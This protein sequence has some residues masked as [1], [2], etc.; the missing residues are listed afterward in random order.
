MERRT[1]ARPNIIWFF[2]DQHRGQATGYAGDP[3]LSTPTM[4]RMAREGI[5]VPGAI[6]NNPWCSPFRF[7]LMTGLYPHHGVYRN[8]IRMDPALPTVATM[9]G[10]AGYRTHYYGK[11]HLDAMSDAT[12]RTYVVP[13]ERAIPRERRG[14]FDTWLGH[15]LRNSHWDV[16]LHGHDEGGEVAARRLP[17]YETDCLTELVLERIGTEHRRQRPTDAAPFFITC[18][19]QPPHWP[20][21]APRE[22]MTRHTP[23]RVRLRPNVPLVPRIREASRRQHAGYY[24]QIENIDRNLQR[25]MDKLYELGISDETLLF[26]FSDHGDCMGSH[27]YFEKSSPWEESIRIPFLIHG[28]VPYAGLRSDALDVPLSAVDI[29]PTTLGLAGAEKPPELPGFDWSPYHR[30]DCEG[31]DGEPDSVYI[32]QCVRKKG[33]D[34]IDRA[35]R[36]VVT[37]EGWKYVCLPHAPFV[38]FNLNEDP[39]ETANL[40]FN[41]RF[42]AERER[43]HARLA[44]WIADTGDRFDLPEL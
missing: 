22:D 21:L 7:S 28:G 20:C 25:V 3:N 16:W 26:Y 19:V 44:Q 33:V 30:S 17:G 12:A 4:D 8:N 10:A 9:L 29:L 18:S 35:W 31:L 1:R 13:H 6:A 37:R 36:G 14:G 42:M 24:A 34:G 11:W 5:H 27:A 43:L 32:Q 39:F 15:E 40:A 38:L 23:G 2:S 41:T